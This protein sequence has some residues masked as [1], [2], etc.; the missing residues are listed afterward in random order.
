VHL[1][2]TRLRLVAAIELKS[3]PLKGANSAGLQE[4]LPA[5]QGGLGLPTYGNRSAIDASEA[6]VRTEAFWRESSDRCPDVGPRTAAVKRSLI[7]L[8]A[9]TFAPSGG[10]VAAATTS[11]PERLCGT[12][13]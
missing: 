7:T 8:K 6:L 1:A 4:F 2:R 12:P 13:H 3:A 5:G 10:I 9:L 11:L